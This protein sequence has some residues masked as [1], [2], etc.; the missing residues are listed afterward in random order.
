MN[1]A[2][3]RIEMEELFFC[4]EYEHS[5]DSQCRVSIPSEWRRKDGETRLILF[6]GREKDLLLL[7]FESFR[8]FLAAARKAAFASRSAQEALAHIGSRVRDCRCDK[9]GRIKIDRELLDQVGI[10]EQIK[11][12]GAFTHIK[13][14]APQFWNKEAAN[15]DAYLDEFQ[16]MIGENGSDLMR[17]LENLGGGKKS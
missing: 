2:D 5:L 8:D 16:K 17:L 1:T 15:D 10:T 9:Q 13:L 6:P 14:C 3:A 12:V 7:P 4:G 11:M